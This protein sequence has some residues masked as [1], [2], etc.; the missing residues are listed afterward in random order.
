MY[1]LKYIYIYMYYIQRR[2][3]GQTKRDAVAVKSDKNDRAIING[4]TRFSNYEQNG[5]LIVSA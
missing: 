1:I 4:Q 5:E 2:D 3:S